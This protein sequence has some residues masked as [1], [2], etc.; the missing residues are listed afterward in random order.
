VSPRQPRITAAQLLH[1][2]R[3]DGW[4]IERQRG[5]HAQLAHPTKPGLVTVPRHPGEIL[6][7]KTLASILDQ[8]G[9]TV[10]DLRG[11]L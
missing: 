3:R 2:L 10:D 9:L 8:A 7:P 1:A 5:V 6:K 11:L 4:E